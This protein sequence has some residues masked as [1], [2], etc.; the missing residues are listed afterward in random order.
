MTV[1]VHLLK[2]SDDVL[3]GEALSQLLDQL[4]GSDDRSLLVDEFDLDVVKLG[5]AIDSAQTPPFLTDRRIV[6]VR[7]FGRFSKADDVKELVAYLED[8][9]DSSVVVLVGEKAAKPP[10]DSGEPAAQ[11]PRLPPA[12]TKA[13]TAAGGEIVDTDPQSKN[14]AGWVAD[15]FSAAGLDVDGAVRNRLVGSL[16]D[17]AGSLVGL[18]EVLKGAYGPGTRLGLEEVEPFLGSAGGVPPW[19]LTD[20]IDSGDVPAALDKL[21]RMMGGGD[22]HPLA[23]MGPLQTHYIRMLRLD[24]S[25]AQGEKDAAQVLGIKGSTFPAKKALNQSKKLGG[26][27][28]RRAVQLVAGADLDLRGASVWPGELV[29]EVLVARLATLSRARR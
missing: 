15:Q 17:D 16:G 22:R 7:H 24:G 6:V 1:P 11:S 4:V 2:G 3:L 27:A 25:G 21:G 8:P 5:G 14:M 19:E 23:I 18:I 13:V 10:S 20:A 28:V 9:L 26:P 29:M 12:L